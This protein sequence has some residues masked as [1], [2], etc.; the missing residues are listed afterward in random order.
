MV[1]TFRKARRP[2]VQLAKYSTGKEMV[3][4]DREAGTDQ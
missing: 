2:L 3:N 4:V 1:N